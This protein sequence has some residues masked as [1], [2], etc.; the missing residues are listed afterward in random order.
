MCPVFRTFVPQRRVVAMAQELRLWE[1]AGYSNQVFFRLT[2]PD[3]TS[4]DKTSPDKICP[5]KICPDN[6]CP[7]NI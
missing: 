4:P 5:D 2:C 6:I 7:D 1:S 3:K